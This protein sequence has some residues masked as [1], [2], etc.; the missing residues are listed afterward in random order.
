MAGIVL[1]R[2][3]AASAFAPQL[4]L[5]GVNLIPKQLLH[6]CPGA[7]DSILSGNRSSLALLHFQSGGRQTLVQ[8]HTEP[9][10]SKLGYGEGARLCQDW[11]GVGNGTGPWRAKGT[12]YRREAGKACAK[13]LARG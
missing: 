4:P 2:S 11:I 10:N 6:A 9:D 12:D 13:V 5:A 3:S 7:R 8:C 1:M